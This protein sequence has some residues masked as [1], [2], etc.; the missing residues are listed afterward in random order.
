V[1][2]PETQLSVGGVVEVAGQCPDHPGLAGLAVG[3]APPTPVR[4][5]VE[6][7]LVGVTM[8]ERAHLVLF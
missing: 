5:V 3:S 4:F 1:F 8:H 7:Q 2:E 6:E